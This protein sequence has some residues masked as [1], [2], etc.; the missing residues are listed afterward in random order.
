MWVADYGPKAPAVAGRVGDGMSLSG[1]EALRAPNPVD[2]R[3]PRPAAQARREVRVG[4]R[5][6]EWKLW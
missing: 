3:L 5:V 4:S 2:G 1:V 6:P